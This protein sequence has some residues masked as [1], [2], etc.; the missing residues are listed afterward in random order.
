MN[1]APKG[2][3]RRIGVLSVALACASGV[4]AACSSSTSSTTSATAPSGTASGTPSAS[5]APAAQ[6]TFG[7]LGRI[8]EPASSSATSASA[9]GRG[10]TGSTIRIGVLADPSVEGLDVEYW[11]TAKA[12][13]AWCNAAGGINGRKIVLD[14]RDAAL[15]NVAAQV[16]DACQSDF[17]LVG[18]GNPEDAAGVQPRLA[19]KLGAVW[20]DES[21]TQAIDAPLQVAPTVSSFDWLQTGPFRLLAKKYPS[22]IEHLGAGGPNQPQL[23]AQAQLQV[24]A[25]EAVG[26]KLVNF[27]AVDTTTTSFQPYVQSSMNA[28]VKVLLP[29]ANGELMEPYLQAISDI[30]YSPDAMLLAPYFYVPQTVAAAKSAPVP[31]TWIYLSYWPLEL[32]SQNPATQQAIDMIKPYGTNG[33][34]DLT[35]IMALDSWLLWAKSASACGSN[36]TSAC[37][38]AKAGTEPSWTA[39][40]LAA[41]VNTNPAVKKPS[42]CIVMLKL[43]SSGFEYDRSMTEPTQSIYN[44]NPS[45]VV[46]EP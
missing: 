31:P 30:G 18:G 44:C 24:K 40:G 41:P 1:P 11:Q 21:S 8:C 32:A 5:S 4:T 37:I 43:T 39:G 33:A 22:A 35:N 15:V 26:Y 45:N 6:G 27:Q 2:V 13:A 42:D 28:G 25:A 38:L 29:S 14:L 34:V 3:L 16:T 9:G 19:C 17:M 10:L 23:L 12:F 36:L 46:K 7:D 20:A